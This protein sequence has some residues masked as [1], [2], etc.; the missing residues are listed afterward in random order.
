MSSA[1][2]SLASI[3]KTSTTRMIGFEN[4]Q[5][6]L[7][8][9]EISPGKAL[10]DGICLSGALV[11]ADRSELVAEGYEAALKLQRLL[12]LYPLAFRSLWHRPSPRTSQKRAVQALMNRAVKVGLLVGGNRSGKTESGAMIAA[13]VALGRGDPAVAK[14]MKDNGIPEGSIF[15]RP[16]RVCCVSL[17]S[18]ESIRV[19]RPKIEQFLPA[20]TFWKNRHGAGEAVAQLPNG[21]TILFKTVD[22]GA[23]SYQA[24]AWDLCWFDEDP[25]DEA[26]HNEA[27]MRL[28]DRRGWCLITMTPLRGLTWVWDRFVN[29]PEAGSLCHW[30]H[31]EDNPYIPSDE[32]EALLA[33]YGSH[34]RAAR[35]RV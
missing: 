33:S 20:G 34:E 24:D 6:W 9:P 5:G 29:D 22:Q 1:S 35:A 12:G 25:E 15:K 18:N 17:T 28:V 30:I 21:G 19:Q 31:G 8:G 7:I 2:S 13:A 14:W 3:S 11:S 27:R 26:V 23:R 32:L 4:G 16:G 10:F